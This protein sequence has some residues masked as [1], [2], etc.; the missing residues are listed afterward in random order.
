L[1]VRGGWG[2]GVVVVVG[3]SEEF[4]YTMSGIFLPK[5]GCAVHR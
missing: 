1:G 2:G 5:S 3:R 4:Q